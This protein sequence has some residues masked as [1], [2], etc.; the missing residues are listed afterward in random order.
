MT[1]KAKNLCKYFGT[2]RTANCFFKSLQVSSFKIIKNKEKKGT[3]KKKISMQ[4]K[5]S[6]MVQRER[7]TVGNKK[8]KMNIFN[9]NWK[10]N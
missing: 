3:N 5:S 7:R 6:L 10:S 4:S 8:N 1:Q 9:Q 2:W